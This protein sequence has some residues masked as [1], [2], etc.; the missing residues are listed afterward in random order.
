MYAPVGGDV[1]LACFDRRHQVA[2]LHA[3]APDTGRL[4]ALP[5]VRR[6]KG[7]PYRRAARRLAR[8][9]A[10]A[11][12]IRLGAVT[13]RIPAPAP[14][15]SLRPEQGERRI[16]TGHVTSPGGLPGAAVPLVWLPYAQVAEHVADL[17]VADLGLFLQGYVGGWIPDGWITLE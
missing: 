3:G 4:W 16:F 7:E 8:M 9:M 2:L 17:G 11:G 14:G 5:S 1:L 15:N 10:P 6:G 13:G 12:A